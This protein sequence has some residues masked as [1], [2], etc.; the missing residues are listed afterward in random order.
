MSIEQQNFDHN[1]MQLIVVCKSDGMP[2]EIIQNRHFDFEVLTIIDDDYKIGP[3]VN[4]AIVLAKYEWIS[5]LDDDDIF[6]SNKL[7]KLSHIIEADL[8]SGYIHNAKYIF[9]SHSRIEYIQNSNLKAIFNDSLSSRSVSTD[10]DC[11]HNGSSITFRKDIIMRYQNIL[12]TLEGGIDT[13]IYVCGKISNMNS[14]CI[15][16]ALTG[17]F[18]ND[19]SREGREYA[20]LISNL[21]RQCNSYNFM[22][23]IPELSLEM[24]KLLSYRITTNSLKM[25]ILDPSIKHNFA[26]L[27][28]LIREIIKNQ[29]FTSEVFA[30]ILMALL[31]TIMP[32]LSEKSYTIFRKKKG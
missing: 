3:K 27:S 18:V 5:I 14:H 7:E 32:R 29:R 16:E 21:R 17:F 31:R 2:I 23:V 28:A 12:D 9:D 19:Y 8:N 10:I 24:K 15:N 4:R 30:L 26:K 6:T 11:E 20:S 13:F 22:M 25:F 1:K